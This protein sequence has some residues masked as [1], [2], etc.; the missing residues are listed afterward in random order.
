[1]KKTT[2]KNAGSSLRIIGGDWR[3]RRIRF[4]SDG[5]RPTADRVRETLFNWLAPWINDATCLDVFAGTGALGFEALSRGA[6][7]VTF[8]ERD[9]VAASDLRTNAAELEASLTT[10]LTTKPETKSDDW[11]WGLGLLSANCSR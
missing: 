11:L 8:V 10:A 1:M 6:A 2:G 7:G 5:I 9:R 3:G 4:P